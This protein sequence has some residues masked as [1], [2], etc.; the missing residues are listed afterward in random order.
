MPL[1]D[2]KCDA[3]LHLREEYQGI[4]ESKLVR[5]PVC[6]SNRYRRLISI[7]SGAMEREFQTPIELHSIAPVTD[8]EISAFKQRN[9]GVDLTPDGVPLAR[10]RKQKLRI[11]KREGFQELG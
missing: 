5:C 7:P 11:L 1:Y 10:T 8:W 2:Y 4:H 6:N 9:P 3:C